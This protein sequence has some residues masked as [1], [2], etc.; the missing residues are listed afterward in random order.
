MSAWMMAGA[1]RKIWFGEYLA[2]AGSLC[3]IAGKK[4]CP[5]KHCN[6]L[7]PR[8]FRREYERFS[9]LSTIQSCAYR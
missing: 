4:I 7:I 3:R 9:P 1:Y 6:L 8:Y 2:P 5:K